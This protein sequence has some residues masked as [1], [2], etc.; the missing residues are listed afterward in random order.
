MVALYLEDATF[1][2]GRATVFGYLVEGDIGMA[3]LQGLKPDPNAPT[4][5]NLTVEIVSTEIL[6]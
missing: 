6:P 1:F 4:Q 2:D 5:P 3:V